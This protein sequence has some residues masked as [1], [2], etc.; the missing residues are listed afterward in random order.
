GGRQRDL[1]VRHHR[2]G[3]RGRGHRILRWL[4]DVLDGHGGVSTTSARGCGAYGSLRSTGHA[5][6]MRRSRE[7]GRV[8]GGCTR[9]V[10]SAARVRSGWWPATDAPVRRH[11]EAVARP[12]PRNR[13]PT[14][15]AETAGRSLTWLPSYTEGVPSLR[16]FCGIVRTWPGKI[17]S[18][19]SM[20][21]AF[22]M[23]M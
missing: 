12:G 2:R 3:L 7:L 10:I 22:A 5:A 15:G 13:H 17:R 23:S 18:G 1:V 16:H 21:D 9:P 6:G 20:P 19:F 14:R 4:H 8:A 11:Q